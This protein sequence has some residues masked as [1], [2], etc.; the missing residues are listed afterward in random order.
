MI[1]EILDDNMQSSV[2]RGIGN[3]HDG[4]RP[5]IRHMRIVDG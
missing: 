1:T 2:Y 3:D 5:A 4:V